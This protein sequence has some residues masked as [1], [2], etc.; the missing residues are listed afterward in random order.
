MSIFFNGKHYPWNGLNDLFKFP[1]IN[2]TQKFRFVFVTILLSS[3]FLKNNFLDRES[4]SSGMLRLYGKNCFKYI[5]EPIIKGKFGEKSHKIP[6]RWM[7]GRLKQRLESRVNGK[8]SLV[9]I[10][11]SIQLLTNKVEKYIVESKSS[12]LFKGTT[13]SSMKIDQQ[14]E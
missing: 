10:P 7:S 13:V 14:N 11:G 4:L 9:F 6:L 8:E 5:W 12:F 2:I 1:L 3:S